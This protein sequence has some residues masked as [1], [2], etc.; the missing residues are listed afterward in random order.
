MDIDLNNQQR[1]AKVQTIIDAGGTV[2]DEYA[3]LI[4]RRALFTT[5][6]LNVLER[7]TDAVIGDGD[8]GEISELWALATANQVATPVAVATVRNTV[9]RTIATRLFHEYAITAEENYNL[10]RDRFNSEADAFTKAHQIIPATVEAATLVTAPE[11]T[12]KA[13]S[14]GQTRAAG[15]AGLVPLLV[16]AAELAGT[17][18]TH[19][20]APIGL[21]ADVDGL[22]RRR[23]WEAWEQGWTALLELGAKIQAPTLDGY[24]DYR[25]PRP[26]ETQHVRS[27]IGWRP[28]EVDPED[29]G[30]DPHAEQPRFA[31]I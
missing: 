28:V 19:P 21:I 13:W 27:G 1:I 7:L 11:K 23:V 24:R 5:A 16:L 29:A 6:E 12:R 3:R 8:E 26:L 20:T 9:D 2:T 17:R 31:S 4:E 15:L 22:H 30:Y 18:V 10:L 14:D 25:E